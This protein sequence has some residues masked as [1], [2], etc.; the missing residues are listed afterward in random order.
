MEGDWSGRETTSHSVSVCLMT[1]TVTGGTLTNS[2]PPHSCFRVVWKQKRE[3]GS[4]NKCRVFDDTVR[5]ILLAK[6]KNISKSATGTVKA[7]RVSSRG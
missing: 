5:F 4:V 1:I 2:A 3:D 7:L 6:S